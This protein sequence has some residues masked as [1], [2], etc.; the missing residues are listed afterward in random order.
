MGARFSWGGQV[1]V[2]LGHLL[3]FWGPWLVGA[4]G[5][6]DLQQEVQLQAPACYTLF[7]NA[8]AGGARESIDEIEPEGWDRTMDLLLR[9]VAMGIRYAAPHMKG[10]PS[11]K[12]GGVAAV[13]SPRGGDPRARSDSPSVR[14]NVHIVPYVASGLA[15]ASSPVAPRGLS[16]DELRDGRQLTSST[17]GL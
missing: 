8:G 12:T 2:R 15:S 16:L 10:R 13:G 7:N 6:E 14:E 3:A 11:T 5:P 1:A 4:V 17:H 9:S